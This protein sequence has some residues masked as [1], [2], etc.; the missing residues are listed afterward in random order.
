MAICGIVRPEEHLDSG[1]N[2]K[3]DAILQS[4][5]MMLFEW[6]TLALAWKC[7]VTCATIEENG[8]K[9]VF[10]SFDATMNTIIIVQC[11][12]W[13]WCWFVVLVWTQTDNTPESLTEI[14]KIL[15]WNKCDFYSFSILLRFTEQ[16]NTN[17]KQRSLHALRKYYLMEVFIIGIYLLRLIFQGLNF[18]EEEEEKKNSH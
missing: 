18:K 6:H 7:H 5:L 17:Q 1:S 15:I 4:Q 2:G 14:R 8:K 13:C 12:S 9:K 3:K 16:K 10:H 11:G